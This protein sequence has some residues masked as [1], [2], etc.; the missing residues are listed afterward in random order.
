[1]Y[2]HLAKE[3]CQAFYEVKTP[4]K[5]VTVSVPMLNPNVQI[6]CDLRFD[7]GSV[8]NVGYLNKN[9][10]SFPFDMQ[11]KTGKIY[12]YGMLLPSYVKPANVGSST[13]SFDF[14][15]GVGDGTG[16][17][18]DGNEGA[19]ITIK[20]ES[21]P[22]TPSYAPYNENTFVTFY[23]G[24]FQQAAGQLPYVLDINHAV[25]QEQAKNA[26]NVGIT[27]E[28]DADPERRTEIEDNV[29]IHLFDGG[30]NLLALTDTHNKTF[31]NN[32]CSLPDLH[33]KGFQFAAFI[34]GKMSKNGEFIF[35]IGD[36]ETD[37]K[38]QVTEV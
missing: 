2:L 28:I 10:T 36:P 23:P 9:Q 13:T 32:K 27:F 3:V 26:N 7:D 29:W 14:L 5:S 22:F 19:K 24:E 35:A 11:N 8:G 25:F 4:R 33:T 16:Q 38:V 18:F 17:D 34:E 6:F 37:A 1:M 31:T 21:A 15:L 20:F 30:G 12:F